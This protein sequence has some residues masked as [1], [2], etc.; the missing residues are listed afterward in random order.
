MRGDTGGE[1]NVG[2]IIL[3]GTRGVFY[4]EKKSAVLK[5]E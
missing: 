3:D 4:D 1:G 2:E 5:G